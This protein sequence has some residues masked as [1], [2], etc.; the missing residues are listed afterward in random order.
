M[1]RKAV[2]TNTKGSSQAAFLKFRELGKIWLNTGKRL[3]VQWI[4]SHTGIEGNELADKEAK[5]YAS[6]RPN[7]DRQEVQTLANAK[8]RIR[9]KKAIAWQAEWEKEKG[10][11]AVKTYQDLGLRPTKNIK[12]MPEM[13]LKRET[14]G[15]L[16]AARSGHGHFADYHERF[17]HVEEA[18]LHC[19]CGARRAQL[20][21]FICPDAQ[22][23]RTLLWCKDRK[24]E[25]EPSEV[26]STKEGVR[27]L[28][29]WA[30]ATGLF[31]KGGSSNRGG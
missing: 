27:I 8:R 15:W 5:K 14:L 28:A 3:T 2:G 21:P 19:S 20:H 13:V 31:K 9:A 18:D 24:R 17:N 1:L 6:R 4:P 16:S 7:T 30:S 23:Y 12:A 22:Q 10:V 26:I 25:L 11:G 29:Q